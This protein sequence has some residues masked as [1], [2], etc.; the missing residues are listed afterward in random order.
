MKLKLFLLCSTFF[1]I[2]CKHSKQE[3]KYDVI[4][5]AK[6][7]NT[8]D[9]WGRLSE[10]HITEVQKMYYGNDKDKAFPTTFHSSLHYD[11]QTDQQYTETE[12]LE[13]FN[14]SIIHR[15][16]EDTEEELWLKDNK[17]TLYYSFY[18]YLAKNKPEYAK[19]IR[20]DIDNPQENE[21]R[22]EYFEY[23]QNNY[24]VKQS[25]KNLQTKEK[26]EIY[27]FNRVM[28]GD[29][30]ITRT[31]IDGVLQTIRKEFTDG[32]KKIEQTWGNNMELISTNTEYEEDGLKVSTTES[33]IAGCDIDSIYS[34]NGKTSYSVQIRTSKHDKTLINKVYDLK[35]NVSHMI[36]RAKYN[37]E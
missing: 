11:Y 28:Q 15:Y 7:E 35:G 5:T 20:K 26:P 22:E 27:T 29:T 25:I 37:L 16:T 4:T 8:Y 3:E 1:I 30:L 6:Y 14:E 21:Y 34:K 36:T 31:T 9:T 18:R 13:D 24:L 32:K 10:V 12:I 33:K 17:D 23:D 2:S 19:I